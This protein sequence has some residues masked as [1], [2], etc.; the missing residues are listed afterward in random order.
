MGKIAVSHE[1]R[2]I[3]FVEKNNKHVDLDNLSNWL[4]SL[5]NFQIEKI[6]LKGPVRAN[7]IH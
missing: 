2:K 5:Q 3:T 7:I 6:L 1:S 4:Q